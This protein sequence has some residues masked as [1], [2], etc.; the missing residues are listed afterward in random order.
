VIYVLKVINPNVDVLKTEFR[1]SYP[2]IRINSI[3][4]AKYRIKDIR[5]GKTRKKT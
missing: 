5:D 2:Y 1:P 4:T 3:P